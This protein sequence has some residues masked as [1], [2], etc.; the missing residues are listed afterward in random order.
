M[1]YKQAFAFTGTYIHTYIHTHTVARVSCLVYNQYRK[2]LN[3]LM[4]GTLITVDVVDQGLVVSSG[5]DWEACE[6]FTRLG[7]RVR[8]GRGSAAE[9]R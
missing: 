7:L 5:L 1:T 8:A 3:S 9:I 6:G 2:I 4:A